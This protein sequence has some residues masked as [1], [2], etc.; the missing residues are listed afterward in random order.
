VKAVCVD[1]VGAILMS[2]RHHLPR[3]VM[4]F[5]KFHADRNPTLRLD[6]AYNDFPVELQTFVIE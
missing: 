4:V 2:I 1:N 3:A 6:R 5:D